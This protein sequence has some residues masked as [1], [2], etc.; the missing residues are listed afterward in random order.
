M[1]ESKFPVSRTLVTFISVQYKRYH[2]VIIIG[3]NKLFII[4][5]LNEDICS[6]LLSMSL[7]FFFNE[8]NIE[9]DKKK[10]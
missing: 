9:L 3:G 4:N 6:I 8:K 5:H 2:W 10:L 1:I 7:S